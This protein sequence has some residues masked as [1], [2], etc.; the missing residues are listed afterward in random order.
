MK[1][2]VFNNQMSAFEALVAS[3][4]L[5]T[6]CKDKLSLGARPVFQIHPDAK[7]LIAGQAPGRKVHNS[8]IPFD[9]ASGQ[10]LREWLGMS[11]ETFYNPK[12][13]AILPMGFCYPGTGK[14]G[15]MAPLI[16]CEAA[17]RA[18]LLDQLPHLK[19]TLVLGQYAQNYHFGNTKQSLTQRVKTWQQNESN[20]VPLPHPSPRNNIWLSK[21][22]WFEKDLIP[23]LKLRVADVLAP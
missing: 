6:I 7:I 5:C 13:V 14:N 10:R 18:Q 15:D 3:I 19:M 1:S 16:E 12:V 21:N 2:L 20:E 4:K 9:D 23:K 22:R 17:W 11:I 8:G